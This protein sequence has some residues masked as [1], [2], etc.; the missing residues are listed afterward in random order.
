MAI[1]ADDKL[2]IHE[3]MARAAFGYDQR[4]VEMLSGCFAETAQMS[5]RIAGG[6]L[7]GPFNG[8]DEV[9]GLMTSSM[10][11]Q[12]DVRRHVISNLFFA[13]EGSEPEVVSNL[14]LLVI[15]NGEIQLM[16]SGIY[17]DQVAK[18]DGRWQILRRHLDLD[19][20]Y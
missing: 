8:R 2:A 20:G 16:S 1:F 15:E 19:K 14:T 3:L 13:D 9:M 4:D 7:V 6:D 10:E 12:T 17:R 18:L 5:I 11:Q